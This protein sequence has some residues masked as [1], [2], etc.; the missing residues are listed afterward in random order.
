M[1]VSVSDQGSIQSAKKDIL[2][3][4]QIS[5]EEEGH[6]SLCENKEIDLVIKSPGV[7]RVLRSLHPL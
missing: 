3:Q 4:E 6:G 5:F 1:G 2:M 7:P